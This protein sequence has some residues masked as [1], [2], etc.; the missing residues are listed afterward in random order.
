MFT[1]WPAKLLRLNGLSGRKVERVNGNAGE[2]GDLEVS[3]VH[4]HGL[5]YELG[6][7]NE[8]GRIAAGFERFQA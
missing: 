4:R 8:C 1:V 3:I 5:R 2:I 7:W 6:H